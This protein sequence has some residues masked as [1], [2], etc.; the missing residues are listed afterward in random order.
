[1][2][3]HRF[4][5][6]MFWPSRSTPD[7][8][9]YAL[10]LLKRCLKNKQKSSLEEYE[11]EALQRMKKLLS[12]KWDNLCQQAEDSIAYVA[13]RCNSSQHNLDWAHWGP[14]PCG[15]VGLSH[16]SLRHILFLYRQA[17]DRKKHDKVISSSQERAYWRIHRPPPG[18]Q[19]C[20]ERCPVPN[21]RG[22]RKKTMEQLKR[23]IDI[24]KRNLIKSRNK[25]TLWQRCDDYREF[26]AFLSTPLPSNP[27]ISDD[28]SFWQIESS[29]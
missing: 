17:K 11:Q 3:S 25:S 27:W 23:Q 14:L 18:I 28:H 15:K 8:T 13:R 9:D 21:K 5:S 7:N 4:Q 29:Q 10:Y 24:M 1:M 12:A 26:D 22:P 20:L 2:R 6:P 16:G 19:S